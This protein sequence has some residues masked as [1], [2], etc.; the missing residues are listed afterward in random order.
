[1][2]A[3]YVV[4]DRELCREVALKRIHAASAG[5]EM[6]ARFCREARAVA[7]ICHPGVPQ[8]HHTGRTADG[9]S[10]FTMEIVRGEPLRKVLDRERMSPQRALDVAI[11]LGRILAAAHAAGVIHR[12]VKP[13]NIMLAPGDR[14]RLLDFGVCSPL[15]RFLAD[16]EPRRRT[17]DI[18]RWETGEAHFAGTV[19]YSDP[20]THDG[21]PATVRSDLFSL[22]VLLYEMLTGRRLFDPDGYCFRT[23]DSAEFPLELTALAVDLRKAASH[24]PF[25]RQRSITEFVQRLE[26]ARGHLQRA[27]VERSDTALRS[28]RAGRSTWLLLALAVG[29]GGLVLGRS[30]AGD[31]RPAPAAAAATADAAPTDRAPSRGPASAAPADTSADASASAAPADAAPA[32]AEPAAATS[33]GPAPPAATASPGP[34]DPP[35]PS[36]TSATEP[37]RRAAARRL[38]LDRG[39]QFQRCADLYNPALRRLTLRVELDPKGS[40]G[41][42]SLVGRTP[43]PLTLCLTEALSDLSFPPGT[44]SPL[45]HALPLRSRP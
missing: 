31:P 3:V 41:A 24:N 12:D 25:E 15:P 44:P 33:P 21:T 1:M 16:A 27:Q 2:G 17:A 14:V 38:L 28:A 5:P 20:A 39:A 42:V 43:S 32:D 37:E 29:L 18:D 8:V 7:A 34:A 19:G 13:G 9:A 10:W 35:G 26:I 22:A 40:P 6:E 23:I 36:P 11:E 4:F 30:F 45:T